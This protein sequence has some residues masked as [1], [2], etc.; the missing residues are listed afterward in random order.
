MCGGGTPPP[1]KDNSVELLQMQLAA[2]EAARLREEERQRLEQ[3]QFDERLASAFDSSVAEAEQNIAG[4][5]LDINEFLPLIMDDL[6]RAKGLVPNLDPTP[7]QYFSGV[8]DAALQGERDIR[9][10]NYGRQIDA[11]APFGFANSRIQGTLDDDAI[12]AILEEDLTRARNEAQGAFDRGV[13]TQTGLTGAFNELDRQRSGVSARLQ[14]LGGGVLEEGRQSLRDI[15][16]QG[17]TRASLYELGGQFNPLDFKSRIDNA[18]VDF[19]NALDSRLRGRV[20]PGS[21]FDTSSLLNIAGAAQGAQN[22][23][24][25]LVGGTGKKTEDEERG[26]GSTGVF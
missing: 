24:V 21:L 9:R 2:D 17:R 23:G 10:G 15:A 11:F 20:Q 14:D 1:P 7:Q 5:G 22:T 13:L 18:F 4:R 6:Q 25:S 26:L 8:V 19:R 3:G 12:L 16:D